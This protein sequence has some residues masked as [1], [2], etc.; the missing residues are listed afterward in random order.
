MQSKFLLL[1]GFLEVLCLL[2]GVA[3][4]A[5]RHNAHLNQ[6]QEQLA[7]IE[8]SAKASE[9]ALS[10]LLLK[11]KEIAD[12]RVETDKKLESADDLVGPLRY[13]FYDRVLREDAARRNTTAPCPA[14]DS[15]H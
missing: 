10:G 13:E 8:K 6:V 3:F 14:A 2:G 12:A 9:Q 11:E 15:V 4:F 1:G 5:G 7:V